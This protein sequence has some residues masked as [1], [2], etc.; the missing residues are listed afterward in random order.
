MGVT[1]HFVDSNFKLHHTLLDFIH[2]E[3]K[4]TGANL[5]NHLITSLEQLGIKEKVTIFYFYY[6]FLS[7][8]CGFALFIDFRYSDGQCQKQRH[9][10]EK[11]MG[12]SG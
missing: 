5:A 1:G 4:H 12:I 7:L 3:E 2:V 9:I 10:D 6:L 11:F 8:T